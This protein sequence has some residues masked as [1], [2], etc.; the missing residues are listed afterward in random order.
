MEKKEEEAKEGG[1]EEKEEKE[2]A[3]KTPCDP[4]SLKYLLSVPYFPPKKFTI[5]WSVVFH[6]PHVPHGQVEYQPEMPS[7]ALPRNPTFQMASSE[8]NFR[9][10]TFAP[11]TLDILF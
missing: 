7:W 1:K 11:R 9:D 10:G 5:S 3:S 6:L 8:R 4:Q 2:Y